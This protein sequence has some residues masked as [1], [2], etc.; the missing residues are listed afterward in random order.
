MW[1]FPHF[2]I[3]I[4][5]S[6]LHSI[7]KSKINIILLIRMNWSYINEHHGW[8]RIKRAD[9]IM[10]TY[11]ARTYFW[12]TVELVATGFEWITSSVDVNI[13]WRSLSWT[14]VVAIDFFFFK[15]RKKTGLRNKGK[16][17]YMFALRLMKE[18]LSQQRYQQLQDLFL[19]KGKNARWNSLQT[20]TFI[21]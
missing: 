20:T 3:D 7:C 19:N 5:F 11:V 6:W 4:R 10:S 8:G 14:S 18:S 1:N 21:N 12:T 17:V 15:D 16:D 2:C 13:G 9:T